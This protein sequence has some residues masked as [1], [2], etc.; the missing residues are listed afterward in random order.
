M[1]G[2]WDARPAKIDTWDADPTENDSG[3]KRARPL[4]S[5]CLGFLL[6]VVTAVFFVNA[7]LS[8]SGPGGRTESN[9]NSQV[10]GTRTADLAPAR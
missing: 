3:E 2:F 10:S 8:Y 9:L 7:Q 4:L 5:F 1:A 6:V